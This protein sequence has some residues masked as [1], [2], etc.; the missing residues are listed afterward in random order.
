MTT[1]RR[2]A[3]DFP[4]ASYGADV[5]IMSDLVPAAGMSSSSALIIASFLALAAV[6]ELGLTEAYRSGLADLPALACYLAAV[7]GGKG[8]GPFRPDHGVGTAGGSEDHTAI[9]C[10]EP[11]C[12]GVYSYRP[13][14]A[15]TTVPFPL[16]W[17]IVVASSGVLAEK[18]GRAMGL[19]NRASRLASVACEAATAALGVEAEDLATLVRLVGASEVTRALAGVRHEEFA[20]DE[21]GRRFEHFVLESDVV[22]PKAVTALKAQDYEEWGRQVDRSQIKGTE[23]LGNQV[24]ETVFLAASARDL[25]A[26]AA[27]AFGAGFGGSVWA[28]TRLSEVEKFTEGWKRAYAAKYPGLAAEFFV[29]RPGPA[30]FEVRLGDD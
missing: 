29:T 26:A 21:L 12:L 7:E 17:C 13:V 27:S 8:Y 2:I 11:D 6:D 4:G 23:L 16:D 30:A 3:R 24:P 18:T 22:I 9:L 19:Y 25:G 20:A 5:A 1:A 28:M 10:S 15:E 14:R